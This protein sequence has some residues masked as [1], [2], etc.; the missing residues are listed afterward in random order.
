VPG[1]G[2]GWER[3]E[4]GATVRRGGVVDVEDVHRH[5]LPVSC[6]AA[7]HKQSAG[8]DFDARVAGGRSPTPDAELVPGVV[9]AVELPQVCEPTPGATAPAEDEDLFVGDWGRSVLVPCRGAVGGEVVNVG[10]LVGEV[11]LLPLH[12]RDGVGVR[13]GFLAVLGELVAFELDNLLL[14]RVRVDDVVL[15]G[16][17]DLQL[18]YVVFQVDFALAPDHIDFPDRFR[19]L[20]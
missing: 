20:D 3:G 13:L 2:L 17:C 8:L 18:V 10:L 6:L 19:E 4:G 11:E 5:G 16:D 12:A 1:L 14:H 9:G 15:P 7:E